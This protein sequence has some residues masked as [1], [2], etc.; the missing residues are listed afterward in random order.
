MQTGNAWPML[1]EDGEYFYIFRNQYGGYMIPK[2]ELGE[3]EKE[4]RLFMEK[5]TKQTFEAKAAPV[6]KLLRKMD[7]QRQ[8][9][10]QS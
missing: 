10:R 7:T 6:L 2:A 3:K 8:K 5:Q 9:S 4:F 1:G